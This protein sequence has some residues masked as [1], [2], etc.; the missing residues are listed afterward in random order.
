M[1]HNLARSSPERGAGG[2]VLTIAGLLAVAL[3]LWV[4]SSTR[5][6]FW[7]GALALFGGGAAGLVGHALGLH[8]RVRTSATWSSRS[9]HSK[10][11]G[12]DVLSRSEP[13]PFVADARRGPAAIQAAARPSGAEHPPSAPAT[14]VPNPRVPDATGFD[15]R[16][17]APRSWDPRQA[18]EPPPRV[19]QS[20]TAPPWATDETIE[21]QSDEPR[22]IERINLVEIDGGSVAGRAVW[23]MPDYATQSGVALDAARLGDLDVRAASVV[24]PSHRCAAPADPRQDAYALLQAASGRYL[25]IAVAD[26]VSSSKRSELGARV[27]VTAAVRILVSALDATR[28]PERIDAVSLFQRVAGEMYGTAQHRQVDPNQVACLL[29]VAVVPTVPERDGSRR[30]WTAQVGDVSVWTCG[31]NGLSRRTGVSK[32]GLDYNSVS[33][34][35]PAHA[36]AATVETLVLREGDGLAVMTDGLGDVLENVH[37]ASRFYASRWARPPAPVAF[38]ADLMADANG[39]LD[40]RTAVVVWTGAP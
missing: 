38:L 39:Q 14:S 22:V 31:R 25:V 35:L 19:D 4:T 37:G 1:F 18:V 33:E 27:A 17:S 15:P 20:T 16:A 13:D 24:G 6:T 28:Q 12:E 30:V 34:V 5:L 36:E 32:G 21:I 23:R 11:P 26:G 40:D 7:G 2:L 8:N 3:L 9:K 29:V 10:S